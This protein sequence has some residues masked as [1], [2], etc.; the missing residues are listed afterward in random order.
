MR[1]INSR[2]YLSSIFAGRVG[3]RGPWGPEGTQGRDTLVDEQ[4]NVMH[5]LEGKNVGGE[6]GQG[7]FQSIIEGGPHDAVSQKGERKPG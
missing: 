3:H 4:V 1:V 2:E 7:G 5:R 6:K